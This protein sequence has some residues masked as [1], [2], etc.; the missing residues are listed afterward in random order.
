[1]FKI[2]LFIVQILFFYYYLISTRYR[3]FQQT[4]R[5]NELAGTSKTPI[6]RLAT[7]AKIELV[8]VNEHFADGA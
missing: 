5:F 6:S 4:P 2:T 1:M 7:K 8:K 3:K